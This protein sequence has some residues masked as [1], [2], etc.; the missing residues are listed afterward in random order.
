MKQGFELNIMVVGKRL[1]SPPV[2]P[3]LHASGRF[4]ATFYSLR[5]S[6]CVRLGHVHESDACV[7]VLEVPGLP[8]PAQYL[9]LLSQVDVLERRYM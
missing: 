1:S 4:P 2:I 5:T 8:V 9:P 3:V 6:T 7:L